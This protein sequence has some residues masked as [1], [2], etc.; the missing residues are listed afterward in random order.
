[1]PGQPNKIRI[2]ILLGML[3]GSVDIFV[4]EKLCACIF[5][6]S[7]SSKSFSI[8]EKEYNTHLSWDIIINL[9]KKIIIGL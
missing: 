3:S 7:K 6:L 1:M 4:L 8:L 9:A 2:G 5:F